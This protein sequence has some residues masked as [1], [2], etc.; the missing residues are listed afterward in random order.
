MK[1]SELLDSPNKWCQHAYAKNSRGEPVLSYAKE[2][3]CWCLIG[4]IDACYPLE[5]VRGPQEHDEIMQKLK[6][7][8]GITNV[9]TWNDDPSRTFEEV[10]EAVLKAGI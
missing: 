10:R 8:I 1:V 6:D 2:A 5:Y 4:A 7:T 3:T 9:A